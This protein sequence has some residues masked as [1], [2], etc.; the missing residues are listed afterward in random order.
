MRRREDGGGRGE[1]GEEGGKCP[2]RVLSGRLQRAGREQA[3]SR[4]TAGRRVK[5]KEILEN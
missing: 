5:S 2:L 4:Q 1:A 3:E